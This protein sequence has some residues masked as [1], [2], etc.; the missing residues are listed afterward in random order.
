MPVAGVYTFAADCDGLLRLWVGE[1]KVIDK[2]DDKQSEVK[3]TIELATGKQ[4]PIK[5]EYVHREGKANAHVSW[6]SR[7]FSKRI[8]RPNG[9]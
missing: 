1:T 4:Y 2:D 3:G 9:S 7:D 6:S 8:L 5:V